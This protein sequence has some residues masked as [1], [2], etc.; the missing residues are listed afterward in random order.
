MLYS[1]DAHWLTYEYEFERCDALLDASERVVQLFRE[2]N[3][4]ELR[5]RLLHRGLERVVWFLVLHQ[6][7]F[8]LLRP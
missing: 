4:P 5:Q 3:M 2:A 6:P 8:H 1:N 7:L